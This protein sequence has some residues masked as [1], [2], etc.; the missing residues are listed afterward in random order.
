MAKT[1]ISESPAVNMIGKGTSI[2][3]DIRSDGDFRVDG[4][5]QGSIHS[6]GK[7]VV[8]VSGSIEGD[9]TCQNADFSGQVKAVIHV[10]ELLSL[11]STSKVIG[12]VHTSK[13]AIEPGAKFSGTC[14][15]EDEPEFK[16][17]KEITQ[18]EPVTRE[19]E[20]ITG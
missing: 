9:I 5:L 12:E 8:G 18:D 11:K 16:V 1:I 4:I 19:K 6:T 20:K 15:M 10:K 7:I 2:K 3:G 14:N 17:Q 13:L